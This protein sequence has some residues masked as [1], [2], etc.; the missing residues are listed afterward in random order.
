MNA[1]IDFTPKILRTIRKYYGIN[2]INMAKA[3]NVAQGTI[4]KM[5]VGA[6]SMDGIQWVSFCKGYKL[7]PNIIT[8][9]RIEALE[10]IKIS[11]KN[12]DA[13]GNFKLPGKYKLFMTSTVRTVYPFI[14]FLENKIGVSQTN[15]FFKSNKVDPDY[16]TVQNLPINL[17]IIEDIFYYLSN[18]G[19]IS[20]ES[21]GDILNTVP[22]SEV[23]EYALSRVNENLSSEKNFKKFT[24]TINN[25]Y[26]KNSIYEFEGEDKCYIKVRDDLHVNELSLSQDFMKFR[27]LYNLSH[28]NKLAPLFS[29]EK[30]FNSVHQNGGWD[31]VS[32]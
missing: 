3:L 1:H 21:V 7:D 31:I 28:F 25:F 8:T 17:R 27:E 4:S 10:D 18:K 16:F 15:E 11:L 6:L 22:V 26:E 30:N 13:A 20:I 14:K 9:G 32:I 12:K 19:L 29:M 5:E 24:K 2:Q 23:H